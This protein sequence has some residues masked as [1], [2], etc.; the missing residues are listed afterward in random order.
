[1]LW[2]ILNLLLFTIIYRKIFKNKT[3]YFF[4]LLGLLAL[5]I[6]MSSIPIF[7]EGLLNRLLTN[8]LEEFQIKTH[9]YPGNY[10]VTYSSDTKDLDKAYSKL[11]YDEI[12][13][14]N[15]G[16]LSAYRE[17]FTEINALNKVS[18]EQV[19]GNFGVPVAKTIA[20]YS[21]D[22]RYIRERIA[23]SE[24]QFYYHG[25]GYLKAI[26]EF[27]Q[28]II[29]TEGRIAGAVMQGN[30]YEVMLSTKNMTRYQFE[31]NTVYELTDT[32]MNGLPEIKIMPV[33]V[34]E[35]PEDDVFWTGINDEE[36]MS[37]S[38]MMNYELLKKDFFNEKLCL[39]GHIKWN[40]AFD[41]RVFRITNLQGF[42][43]G[44]LENDIALQEVYPKIVSKN[45][46]EGITDDYF[47]KKYRMEVLLW[48]LNAPV[49]IM[50]VLYLF[51]LCSTIVNRE[52]SEVALLNSRGASRGQ[53]VLSYFIQGILLCILPLSTGPVI[54]RFTSG[55]LGSATSFLK[56]Q[57]KEV[58]QTH[59]SVTSY[60]YALGASAIFL[61]VF[62]VLTF[63]YS[64]ENILSHR[65]NTAEVN[66][67]P[68]WQK[69]FLDV[70][71]IG[72]SIFG[73]YTF[74]AKMREAAERGSY[75]AEGKVEPLLFFV[76][77]MFIIAVAL[78][79]LRVYPW[80]VK[81]LYELRKSKLRASLYITLIQVSRSMASYQFIVIF[82]AVTIS[83]GLFNSI[84]I[85]TINTHASEQILY[86]NGADMVLSY[87]WDVLPQEEYTGTDIEDPLF[88]EYKPI[89]DEPD[90]SQYG[91][92]DGVANTCKVWTGRGSNI[93]KGSVH[94]KNV[95]IMA[96]D[97]DSFDDTAWFKESLLPQSLTSYTNLL[98][99]DAAGC[100]ISSSLSTETGIGKGDRILFNP[101]NEEPVELTVR[102]V[103]NYW[104]TFNP[105]K[106]TLSNNSLQKLIIVNL[107]LIQGNYGI[108]PYDVW[109]R[110]KTGF[111]AQE[112]ETS[113]HQN[114]IKVTSVKN[115]EEEIFA[116]I[117]DPYQTAIN[118]A[119]SFGFMI[120]GLISI[121]GFLL[122]WSL[123]IKKRTIQYGVLRAV[124]VSVRSL[125]V[126]LGWEQIFITGFAVAS[127]IIAGLASSLLYVPF[128]QLSYNI[129]QMVPPFMLVILAGDIFRVLAITSASICIL[130]SILVFLIHTL[131][132]DRALK[133]GED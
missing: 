121:M 83:L 110:I 14:S 27:E 89:F 6:L 68:L 81:K 114:K 99:S 120:C 128:F 74:L 60:V 35:V 55:M 132:I 23:D 104:P 84:S 54:A 92:I 126:I 41:Y 50:L 115:S 105:N 87:F 9:Q 112:V 38:F 64:K 66:T 103:V 16:I 73:Y 97:A 12:S 43:D 39:V 71:L 36:L 93:A 69:F 19:T 28:H 75:A 124:G 119:F 33:G 57:N 11:G 106:I 113:I 1:M 117:T 95:D 108:T 18:S 76:P 101:L 59:I 3:L 40:Y 61:V 111:T 118:G 32:R 47:E 17:R 127:G 77:V 116:V 46:I 5:T 100:I 62:T 22:G 2:S 58:M 88:D 24:D 90:F 15:E 34:F 85:R 72:G 94:T 44:C 45:T 48:T 30:V 13:S 107:E 130:L 63:I 131:K 7:T 122:F 82:M 67:R 133:L 123:E 96:I 91:L 29:L 79:L 53:I 31:L 4:L 51:M 10:S 125:L 65:K 21:L 70:I 98:A 56:F 52:K 42:I 78:F 49:I 37:E 26:E 20:A 109:L 80:F 86:K 25:Y 129:S 102:E 8:D